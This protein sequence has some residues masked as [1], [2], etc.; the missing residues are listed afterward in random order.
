MT[1]LGVA[2]I[3]TVMAVGLV[4]TVV[5]FVPGLLLVWAAG[6]VYG[7]AEGFGVPGSVAFGIMTV[8]LVIA[9]V[10]KF[11]LPKRIGSAK[12]ASTSALLAGAAVGIVGF[13]VV[14][15]IGLP[16]GA[17][18]GVLLVE[19]ARSGDWRTAWAATRGVIVGFGLG[20]LV[21]L[22]AGVAMVG[23]WVTWAVV[24]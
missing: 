6:G 11:V 14:P 24:S 2:A 16:L 9:T 23:C 3:A 10:L 1:G 22:G 5:P 18:L 15:V 7:L 13:F 17:V 21:E 4:G 19:R 8:L 20:T 12:G